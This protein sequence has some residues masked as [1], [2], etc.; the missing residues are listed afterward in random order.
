MFRA[1]RVASIFMHPSTLFLETFHSTK[2]FF[3]LTSYFS[4]QSFN[5]PA[6][7]LFLHPFDDCKYF[8]FQCTATYFDGI[9]FYASSLNKFFFLKKWVNSFFN[10]PPPRPAYILKKIMVSSCYSVTQKFFFFSE[11]IHKED[12]MLE[13]QWITQHCVSKMAAFPYVFIFTKGFVLLYGAF[14]GKFISNISHTKWIIRLFQ[15]IL[16]AGFTF[17]QGHALK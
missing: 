4:E 1:F 9:T 17:L 7:Q 14:L 6:Q 2:S 8:Q 11:S 10:S 16:R 12:H 13:L 3:T 5:F 15:L